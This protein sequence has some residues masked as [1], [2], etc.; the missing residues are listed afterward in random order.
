VEDGRLE[1]RRTGA[2]WVVV[3]AAVDV[4]AM[5]MTWCVWSERRKQ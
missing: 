4:M 1:L 3:L 2:V 5:A